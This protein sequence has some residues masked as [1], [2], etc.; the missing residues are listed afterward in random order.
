[1]KWS[2]FKAHSV[3]KP[4]ATTDFK[5]SLFLNETRGLLL[6]SQECAI[7]HCPEAR[8]VSARFQTLYIIK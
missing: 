3:R 4:I 6:C 8:D 5:T 1:L 7:E 2:S